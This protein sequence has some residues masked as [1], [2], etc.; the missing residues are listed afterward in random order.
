MFSN[1]SG[2]V[3]I[4]DLTRL[5][6]TMERSNLNKDQ[7]NRMNLIEPIIIVQEPTMSVNYWASS[8]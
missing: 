4:R 8:S 5:G 7:L 2:M 6:V 3:Y 1:Q